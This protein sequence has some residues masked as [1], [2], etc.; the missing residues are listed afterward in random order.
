[1]RQGIP[2]SSNI[3]KKRILYPTI[4][5]CIATA[6]ALL[7][8]NFGVKEKPPVGAET[9]TA[10]K[11]TLKKADN[12]KIMTVTPNN[13]WLTEI[14]KATLLKRLE[15]GNLPISIAIAVEGP[16]H[17]HTITGMECRLQYDGVEAKGPIRNLKTSRGDSITTCNGT[18]HFNYAKA[19]NASIENLDKLSTLPLEKIRIWVK[20]IHSEKGN[21]EWHELDIRQTRMQ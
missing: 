13:D 10:E 20:P 15:D 2:L 4:A 7:F 12:F 3:M 11:W 21:G 6:A 19:E 1:M 18:V 17:T 8:L 5:V 14:M 16:R 9:A